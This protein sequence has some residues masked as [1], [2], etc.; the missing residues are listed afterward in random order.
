MASGKLIWDHSPG[1]NIFKLLMRIRRDELPQIPEN[2]CDEGKDFLGKCFVKDLRKLWM[3]E[4][5]L[6]HPSV[7]NYDIVLVED[8]EELFCDS[9]LIDTTTCLATTVAAV[10][11]NKSQTP[12]EESKC[13]PTLGMEDWESVLSESPSQEQSILR[14][15]MSDIDDPFLG[16]N[17]LLQSGCGFD[18]QDL[19][20]S[21]GWGEENEYGF[22]DSWG[23]GCRLGCVPRRRLTERFDR[24]PNG[25]TTL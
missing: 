4:M 12:L 10:Y 20:F 3:A 15:I 16:L 18:K 25:G 13:G 19:E 17:K 6:S 24:N 11:E 8:K 22:R 7:S 9:G 23:C 5:L 1:V 14:L 2:L 21:V